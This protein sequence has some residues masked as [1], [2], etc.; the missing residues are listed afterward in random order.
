MLKRA[1]HVAA[2][3]ALVTPGASRAVAEQ[4]FSRNIGQSFFSCR[5]GDQESSPI[6]FNRSWD[7]SELEIY[8]QNP[9]RVQRVAANKVTA[10]RVDG[11]CVI[12]I[13]DPALSISV[14]RERRVRG[15]WD[16]DVVATGQYNGQ[17]ISGCQM[18]E[19]AA[20]GLFAPGPMQSNPTRDDF[21]QIYPGLNRD[22]VC[23]PRLI[24]N[25]PVMTCGNTTYSMHPDQ[26]QKIWAKGSGAEDE[27]MQMVVDRMDFNSDTGACTIRIYPIGGGGPAA[28]IAVQVP[29]SLNASATTTLSGIGGCTVTPDFLRL[30]SCRSLRDGRAVDAGPTTGIPRPNA[31]AIGPSRECTFRSGSLQVQA[32]AIVEAIA[33]DPVAAPPP[34]GAPA[35]ES[36]PAPQVG[37]CTLQFCGRGFMP[38][39]ANY[40]TSAVGYRIQPSDGLAGGDDDGEIN[41]YRLA[42]D[43]GDV[44]ALPVTRD[45][46]NAN[47][48]ES[49][50][51][52]DP[53]F[54]PSTS[55][56][57]TYGDIAVIDSTGA[58][59]MRDSTLVRFNI[60]SYR[61]VENAGREPY[62]LTTVAR[63][64]VC[65]VYHRRT[66]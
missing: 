16:D 28:G 40:R 60:L 36:P 38:V 9:H 21:N 50:F 39:G 32:S 31:M 41:Q 61:F 47:F 55:A 12:R 25:V 10:S 64:R 37:A 53:A 45:T 26:R 4:I 33:P 62:N 27:P 66:E 20:E 2:L 14:G 56:T 11:R 1:P 6:Y 54:T 48:P 34:E 3:I 30:N 58:C 8:T 43:Y 44:S 42:R 19:S 65:R 29:G 7:G 15:F 23:D 5:L 22:G 59:Q 18:Y 35:F 13:S 17:P 52:F 57:L 24:P 51:S 63:D 46:F 49:Q